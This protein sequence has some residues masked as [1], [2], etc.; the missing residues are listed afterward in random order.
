MFVLDVQKVYLYCNICVCF[1]R[2]V[3]LANLGCIQYETTTS[4]THL[5]FKYTAMAMMALRWF[6]LN[7]WMNGVGI[8]QT[9]STLI[10][11]CA[12]IWR[13]H[14]WHDAMLHYYNDDDDSALIF[15]ECMDERCRVAWIC[16]CWVFVMSHVIS[17]A[18]PMTMARGSWLLALDEQR[19]RF[20][21]S[22]A[23]VKSVRLHYN[24]SA[25]ILILVGYMYAW[26]IN[27]RYWLCWHK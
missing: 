17:N 12:W 26:W 21:E 2:K 3:I 5:L 22:K 24:G 15:V 4:H 14:G 11:G 18:T 13:W 25:L 16:Y 20:H 19:F 7:V 8:W 27:Q 1:S 6:S 10:L 9:A 23:A